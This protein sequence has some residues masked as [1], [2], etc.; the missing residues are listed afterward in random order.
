[1]L[2]RDPGRL[3]WLIA[4]SLVVV[5]VAYAFPFLATSK[6]TGN[7]KVPPIFAADLSLYL[8]L[9]N[10]QG[11]RGHL[12]DP[13][14][15]V[16]ITEHGFGYLTFRLAFLIFGALNTLC[17]HQLWISALVWNTGLWALIVAGALWL[18]DAALP[19]T[20]PLIK[21]FGIFLLLL[22][23]F[24]V[25]KP[26]AQAWLGLPSVTEF[27]NFD[28]PYMRGFFPPLP[29]AL[30]IPY[31]AFQ[32]WTLRN[33]RWHLWAAM[34][35]LQFL[36]FASFPYATLLMSGCSAIAV[37]AMILR[38]S[39][40]V[41]WPTVLSFAGACAIADFGFLIVNL[42]AGRAPTPHVPFIVFHPGLLPSLIGGSLL[43]MVVS[44]LLV[45]ATRPSAEFLASKWT[46]T[47]LGITNVA[48]LLGDVLFSPSVLQ[49]SQHGGYFVHCTIALQ[50]TYLFAIA[51]SAQPALAQ[52]FCYVLTVILMMHGTLT[53]WATYQ[54]HLTNNQE[55]AAF[56]RFLGSREITG[57]DLII[58]P[59]RNVDD[60][61]AW[62]PLLSQAPVLFCRNAS[63]ALTQEQK[64]TLYRFRQAAYLY[65][66][67][68]DV[69]WVEN[70]IAD[71]NAVNAQTF[72]AF[73]NE[74]TPNDPQNRQ[75]GLS[76][77]QE[78][79]VPVLGRMET[80]DGEFARFSRRYT[81]VIVIDEESN[82]LFDRARIEEYLTRV[83]TYSFEGFSVTEFV[84]NPE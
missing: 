37:A 11:T 70:V 4:L 27:R 55:I 59:A 21:A 61:C 56:S 45:A 67:G 17:L 71:S 2:D 77:I 25:L 50:A 30:L 58:S 39:A 43:L 12:T 66:A 75:L 29:V 48:L 6:V 57:D 3:R 73:P 19:E 35:L 78:E 69:R 40:S 51:W 34:C 24:G 13:Y 54:Q 72:L 18:F 28:L 76:S 32:I 41:R 64:H 7:R 83:R 62:V 1:L 23:N 15:H 46:L 9:S 10:L 44:T 5:L 31:L 47:G 84:P 65:F 63:L 81:R 74:I 22:F 36:A 68:D 60:L 16:P 79:L 14:F 42:G 82:A 52:R 26:I 49:L 20:N 33:S 53:S 8:N 38:P 80:K